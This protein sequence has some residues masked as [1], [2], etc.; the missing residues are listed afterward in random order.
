[1]N[2]PSNV[3]PFPGSRT[4]TERLG[5]AIQETRL[6]AVDLLREAILAGDVDMERKALNVILST[7]HR[8]LL[9]IDMLDVMLKLARGKDRQGRCHGGETARQMARECL[10]RGDIKW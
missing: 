1:M 2:A 10:V 3:T 7:G 4:P 8:S 9:C 6:A 5:D